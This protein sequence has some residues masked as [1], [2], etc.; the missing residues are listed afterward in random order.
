LDTGKRPGLSKGLLRGAPQYSLSPL[1]RLGALIAVVFLVEAATGLLM[2]PYYRATPGEAYASTQHIMRRLPYGALISTVHTYA[3]YAMVLLAFAHLMRGYFV[4]AY[5]R[6]RGPMWV[7]GMFTG[8]VV[9]GSSFTGFLLTWTQSSRAV[10]DA[11]VNRVLRPLP[12]GD[13]IARLVAGQG[14]DGALLTRFF[15]LHTL[16]LPGAFLVLL[17]LKAYLRLRHGPSEQ[18]S[19]YPREGSERLVPWFPGVA[20]HL[21]A[22]AS[23]FVAALLA[24]SAILP[25]T[26]PPEYSP[27]APTGGSPGEQWY[28]LWLYHLLRPFAGGA[29]ILPLSAVGLVWLLL[30]LSPVIDRSGKRHPSDRPVH[31]ALGVLLI[32]ETV[33]LTFWGHLTRGPLPS[34]LAPLILIAPVLAAALWLIR[35]KP[36]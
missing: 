22:T 9:L 6:P 27:S 34:W 29:L 8:C 33:I 11:A 23:A 31:T 28:L 30:L 18:V 21:L 36:F 20:S 25:Y 26:L 12:G 13:W 14:G 7:V 1:H 3:A 32:A 5:R 24:A 17:G 2:L 10:T 15:H 35:R 16:T 19:R 4:A